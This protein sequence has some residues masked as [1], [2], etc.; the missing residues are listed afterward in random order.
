MIIDLPFLLAAAAFGF[1]LSLALYRWIAEYNDWPMGYLQAHRPLVTVSIGL[2]CLLIASAF[3]AAR[4]ML[5]GGW[6]IVLF[7]V[8]WAIFWLGFFRVGS[9]LSLLLAPASA[10]LLLFA[11]FGMPSFFHVD[12]LRSSEVER[13]L[14][15]PKGSQDSE[16]ETRYEGRL[17]PREGAREV[18]RDGTIAPAPRTED[19]TS[20]LIKRDLNR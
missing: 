11:W 5:L 6:G 14:V 7:G 1:G 12:L 13:I 8:L 17:T 19:P 18:T 10:A 2:G 9:Q 16:R 3:A 15:I 4:G 20:A